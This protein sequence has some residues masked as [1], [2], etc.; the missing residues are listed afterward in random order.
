M[1]LIIIETDKRC[2]CTC[3]M[4]CLVMY[5]SGMGERCTQDEIEGAGHKTME[6]NSKA[7]DKIISEF[8][9]CDGD[10]KKIKLSL[11][12]NGKVCRARK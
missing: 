6:L 9:C 10:D 12:R 4:K 11:V 2:T 5:K 3:A 1:A 8:L 7:D